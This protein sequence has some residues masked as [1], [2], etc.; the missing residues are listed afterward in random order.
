MRPAPSVML[1]LRLTSLV[2]VDTYKLPPLVVIG[3]DK[4]RPPPLALS[5]SPHKRT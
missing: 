1:L 3:D 4:V 5:E 2:P